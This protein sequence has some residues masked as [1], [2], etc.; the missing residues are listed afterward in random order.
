MSDLNPHPQESALF[1]IPDAPAGLELGI[2]CYSGEIAPMFRGFNLV[3]PG[4]HFIY[5]NIGMSPKQGF[6]F[7]ASKGD[8]IVRPWDSKNE[9]I[10]TQNNLSDLSMELLISTIQRGEL[11]INMGSYPFSQ[12][13]IWKNLTSLISL[14]VLKRSNCAPGIPITSCNSDNFQDSS[15]I[16]QPHFTD[17]MAVEAKFLEQINSCGSNFANKLTQ[18]NIDKSIILEDLIAKEYSKKWEN[19]LGELQLSFLL[20]M[21]IYSYTALQA[22]KK[23]IFTICSSEKYL[24]SYPLFTIKFL[25]IFY[26][27]LKFTPDDFFVTEISQD[28]FLCPSLSN[29]F[30]S[31]SDDSISTK[32]ITND[33]N[34]WK[35]DEMKQFHESRKRFFNF[36]Q[37]KFSLFTALCL[38]HEDRFNIVAEDLPV[39]V[40]EEISST[41]SEDGQNAQIH[42]EPFLQPM[43]LLELQNA[44]FSWRYPVLYESMLGSQGREDLVMTAMRV[45]EDAAASKALR[46]EAERYVTEEVSLQAAATALRA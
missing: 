4:I 35:T 9:E 6:F 41:A 23:L 18:L 25:K 13:H 46:G 29:L 15:Q 33:I 12:Y 27:Q 7:I 30:S 44:Q 28:N 32:N 45:L 24:K 40:E 17:I 16:N 19:L 21:L 22:W 43:S 39:L 14:N 34:N 42:S 38:P 8:V 31:L 5:H 11:N 20:F 26:E 1:I 3:P 37:K 2:D 10:S 36:I